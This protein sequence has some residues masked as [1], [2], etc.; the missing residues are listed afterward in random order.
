MKGIRMFNLLVICI[1]AVLLTF[2]PTARAQEV[3]SAG[4]ALPQNP[5][6][7]WAHESEV[8]AV[9]VSGNTETESYSAKQKTTYK[10]SENSLTLTGS[11]LENRGRVENRTETTAKQWDAGARYDRVVSEL[12]GAYIGH[13]A[14]A[15][16]FA[17]FIQR[18]ISDFGA[19]YLIRKSDE[20]TWKAEA[21]YAYIKTYNTAYENLYDPSYR[22]Y[23]EAVRQLEKNLS[24]GYWIEYLQ[25]FSKAKVFFIN[26]EASLNVMLNQMFSVK[27]SYLL[28]Y[29][30]FRAPNQEKYTDTTLTTSLIARF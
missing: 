27:T 1:S 16:R 5:A 3:S 4:P 8:A 22:L 14:E 19:K 10:W 25:S 2:A 17:G 20:L 24:V 28:R 29:Q 12:W 21:G 7:S 18:D 23:T 26:T 11:Y 30:N 9:S 6:T 13:R 15:N